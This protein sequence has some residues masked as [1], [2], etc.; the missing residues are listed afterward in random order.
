MARGLKRAGHPQVNVFVTTANARSDR[1]GVYNLSSGQRN[2]NASDFSII[3]DT[4]VSQTVTFS[5]EDFTTG[6][7]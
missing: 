7:D 1:A 3:W 6:I 5:K 2:Y 4:G